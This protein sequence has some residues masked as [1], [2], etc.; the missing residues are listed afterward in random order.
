MDFTH[1]KF[2]QYRLSDVLLL[3]RKIEDNERTQ[4]KSNEYIYGISTKRH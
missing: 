2:L 3:L 4:R 1:L